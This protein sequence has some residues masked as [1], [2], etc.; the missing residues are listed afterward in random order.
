MYMST[1][2]IKQIEGLIHIMGADYKKLLAVIK[3]MGESKH[4]PPVRTYIDLYYRKNGK[5]D[6]K[7]IEYYFKVKRKGINNR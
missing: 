1:F 6:E 7:M 4:I 3:S 5:K 2:S